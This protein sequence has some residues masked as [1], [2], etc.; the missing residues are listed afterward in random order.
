MVAAKAPVALPAPATLERQIVELL[1]EAL[2][3]KG[4]PAPVGS[5]AASGG[6]AVSVAKLVHRSVVRETSEER[7]RF[8]SMVYALNDFMRERDEADY[9]RLRGEQASGGQAASVPSSGGKDLVA[10]EEK[11]GCTGTDKLED[12]PTE[13]RGLAACE[14]V[15]TGPS[16]G[17]GCTGPGV[18]ASVEC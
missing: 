1:T 10:P 17:A 2:K 5:P 9:A 4:S 6:P 11:A 13:H 14:E 18:A 16:G 15:P 12:A 3:S 7:E 8:R